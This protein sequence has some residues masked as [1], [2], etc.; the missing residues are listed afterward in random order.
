[1]CSITTTSTTNSCGT[2]SK[3]SGIKEKHGQIARA[4]CVLSHNGEGSLI[5]CRN[6]VVQCQLQQMPGE[7]ERHCSETRQ[8]N[9]RAPEPGTPPLRSA[10]RLHGI[11]DGDQRSDYTQPARKLNQPDPDIA[12]RAQQSDVLQSH[13]EEDAKRGEEDYKEQAGEANQ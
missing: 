13:R 2:C 9:Q 4:F 6:S 8:S 7:C 11:V 12:F 3:Q 10:P 1:R 5:W